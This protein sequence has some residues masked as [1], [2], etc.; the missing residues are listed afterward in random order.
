MICKQRMY[1]FLLQ[2]VFLVLGPK[3]RTNL[4]GSRDGLFRVRFVQCERL[5][6]S[7]IRLSVVRVR[8]QNNIIVLID[9]SHIK[10]VYHILV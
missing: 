7:L 1:C 6:L 4:R 5:D 8:V 9:Q 2:L 10:F 3:S